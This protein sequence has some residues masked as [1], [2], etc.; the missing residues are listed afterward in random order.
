MAEFGI[1]S[2][3]TCV[4]AESQGRDAIFNALKS[5]RCYGTTG[6]RMLLE[7]TVGD[8][9]MGTVFSNQSQSLEVRAA[10]T[11]TAPLESLQLFQGKRLIHEVRPP[12]FG[13][14]TET[15]HLRISWKGSRERGRQRRVTWDGQIRFEGCQ[16]ESA[17]PFSF[18][19]VADG[20]TS[21]SQHEI[22]F[23]S[24]TTGDRDGLDILLDDTT[25]GQLYFE[26]TAG[27]A[28][29]D[30]ADLTSNNPRQIFD[31]GGVDMQL[32]VERYPAEVNLQSL[33]LMD[34]VTPPAGE[35]TP[36]FVKATQV[37]GEM[38]WAS[39]IYVV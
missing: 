34:V 31:F 17:T 12:A 5:R 39:P 20:I 7:F 32:I 26:S 36:Y 11:G 22:T 19:V 6:A 35:L 37:D 1:E 9:Q 4:L 33:A 24:R 2:G 38:A 13:D 21:M 27:A 8:H 10:V 18:D 14:L 23:R 30:L 28:L 25:S 29:I 16:L 3:L 15:N